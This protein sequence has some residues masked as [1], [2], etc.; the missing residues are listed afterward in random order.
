MVFFELPSLDDGRFRGPT[1]N[2]GV[3]VNIRPVGYGE[4]SD[5]LSG[6]PE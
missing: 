6:V 1:R 2:D 3:V 4:P 5:S